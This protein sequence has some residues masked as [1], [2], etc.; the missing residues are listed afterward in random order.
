V[1]DGSIIPAAMEAELAAAHH[2]GLVRLSRTCW[3]YHNRIRWTSKELIVLDGGLELKNA[4]T[5]NTVQLQEVLGIPG[6]GRLSADEHRL[7]LMGIRDYPF[8]IAFAPTAVLRKHFPTA[9]LLICNILY[10]SYQMYIRSGIVPY[11]KDFSEYFYR[12]LQATL[13]RAGFLTR[14]QL[15]APMRPLSHKDRLFHCFLHAIFSMVYD[16]KLF[17]YREFG[18]K[19]PAT[20]DRIIG[21]TRPHKIL[22]V[23]K[24]D[25]LEVY[26]RQLQEQ[27]DVTLLIL[28]GNPS[29]LASEYCAEALKKL[30]IYEVEVAFYGDSDYSGWDIGPAFVRHL[31][32]Y[33]VQCTRLFRLVMPEC[34]TAQELA[35]F[36]RP[37]DV[38]NLTIA[39]RVK[40][41]LREGGG[42]N[43]EARSIHANWLAPYE[44]LV[45][46]FKE[47]LQ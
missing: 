45:S 25:L 12:P 33:G 16:Y 42:I 1:D 30:G 46:R 31:K 28:K 44:R 3:S 2:P 40:R 34:F 27:F 20:N 10:Q 15:R 37:T 21:R 43:G 14:A 17:T 26:G 7:L 6:F 8:E 36:S 38:P 22:L 24:G 39:G 29:L 32:F 11:G 9:Y 47:F 13:Y 19:D 18:F 41:W 5:I 35:L 23:E 4:P